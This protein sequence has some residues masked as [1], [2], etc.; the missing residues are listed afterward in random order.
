MFK[1]T[2][3][4]RNDVAQTIERLRG[5]LILSC[6]AEGDNPF[7][8]PEHIALFA[9]AGQMGGTC[10]IRACGLDNIRAIRQAT[11]LPIIGI[12]KS[13]YPDGS[14][15]ITGDF[16]DV[17]GLQAA[18]ADI[19]AMDATARKRPNGLSGAEFMCRCKVRCQLPLM[20]DVSNV[21]EGMAAAQAG[22]DIV[23]GTLSGYTSP[24]GSSGNDEPDW[25]LLAALVKAVKIPVIME[26]RVWTPQ[27]A[28]RALRMGAFAVVVGTAI[29]RPIDIV[30]RFVDQMETVNEIKQGS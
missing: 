21:G 10:G 17:E 20:A 12:T 18:G 11:T 23:A 5:G 28:C 29:T 25:Q 24:K 13:R 8:K 2:A 3:L 6:Q 14:V 4:D 27:Q 22:A 15:L 1:E 16:T 7:N 19:I 26:G 30:R 9:R